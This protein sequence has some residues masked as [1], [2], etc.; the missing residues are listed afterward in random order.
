MKYI[1]G[2][3]PEPLPLMDLCRRVIRL[4]LG[5]QQLEERISDLNL[6]HSMIVY[7]LYRDRR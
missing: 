6:P 5:K 7:L 4:R 3:D 1:G 2:L